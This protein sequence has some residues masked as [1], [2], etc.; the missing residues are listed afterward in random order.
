MPSSG[1]GRDGELSGKVEM[2]RRAASFHFFGQ[3]LSSI[4]PMPAWFREAR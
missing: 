1:H 4:T 2:R 3:E